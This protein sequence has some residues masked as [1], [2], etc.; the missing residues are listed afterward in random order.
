MSQLQQLQTRI[1]DSKT[2]LKTSE[3]NLETIEAE[4]DTL[5]RLETEHVQLK[6][7]VRDQITQASAKDKGK[8]KEGF[9]KKAERL[10]AEVHRHLAEIRSR[11]APLENERLSW[12][13]RK[14][15]YTVLLNDLSKKEADLNE[16]LASVLAPSE[17]SGT[18]AEPQATGEAAK[19]AATPPEQATEPT[20]VDPKAG[21]S[22]QKSANGP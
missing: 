8:A 14:G 10:E 19:A 4:L 22:A 6:A 5:K 3:K 11:Y 12:N 9:L 7:D 16:R 20:L 21:T 2:N 18:A 1:L 13:E 15:K 17:T